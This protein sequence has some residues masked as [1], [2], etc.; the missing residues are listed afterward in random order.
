[1]R[2]KGS[3]CGRRRPTFSHR[4]PRSWH[5]SESS[6][7][8]TLHRFNASFRCHPVE[9][10]HASFRM[11][12]LG[13]VSVAPRITNGFTAMHALGREWNASHIQFMATMHDWSGNGFCGAV[14]VGETL[15][16]TVAH[17]MGP[18]LSTVSFG[19][20]FTTPVVRSVQ[21]WAVH[22]DYSSY[23]ANDI[24]VVR[25]EEPI[26]TRFLPSLPID[27]FVASADRALYASNQERPALII[28]GRGAEEHGGHFS[29]TFSMGIVSLITEEECIL[30]EVGAY[31]DVYI[32]WVSMFCAIDLTHI[33]EYPSERIDCALRDSCIFAMDGV[34]DETG[35][36]SG[37][38]LPNSDCSDCYDHARAASPAPS[39][40]EASPSLTTASLPAVPPAAPSAVPPV[41]SS[42]P[43][44]S[45]E[46]V[47]ANAVVGIVVG[48]CV[49]GVAFL[50]LFV[51]GCACS[52]KRSKPE[53]SSKF[54]GVSGAA[55]ATTPFNAALLPARTQGRNVWSAL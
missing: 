19:N 54:R 1:M 50:L 24:A 2:R 32:G 40:P 53:Q 36:L 46:D 25:V 37:A 17:C 6:V 22:P 55:C 5:T 47:E 27:D 13:E 3:E 7:N 10:A 21:Q 15:L 14:A 42:V 49:G 18:H 45:E 28:A 26:P 30:T 44:P 43:S 52:G 33:T 38:C 9:T 35:S 11:D 12:R 4:A 20:G 29:N 23:L 8:L 41:A 51:L 31:I 39:A 16:L 34:C 48:S